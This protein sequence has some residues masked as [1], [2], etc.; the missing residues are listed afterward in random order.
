MK[1]VYVLIG[2]TI[3]IWTWFRRRV[4][5]SIPMINPSELAEA[6]D[7]DCD[8]LL[9]DMRPGI[10]FQQG[11]IPGSVNLPIDKLE[12]SMQQ[13]EAW[14]ERRIVLVCHSGYSSRSAVKYI[15]SK[16]FKDVVNLR[17][18]VMAWRKATAGASWTELDVENA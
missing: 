2:V 15:Q 7:N 4:F 17:G 12:S 9:L 3:L 5:A 16:G 10:H 11:Y 18:G 1:L 8:W 6:L 14:R 13:L